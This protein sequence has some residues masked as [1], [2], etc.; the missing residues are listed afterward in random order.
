MATPTPKLLNFGIQNKIK[1]YHFFKFF[2]ELGG[3]KWSTVLRHITTY[4][5]MY[6]CEFKNLIIKPTYW[7]RRY[8]LSAASTLRYRSLH[9][10]NLYPNV[11]RWA[12]LNLSISLVLIIFFF[13]FYMFEK[14]EKKHLK[15]DDM[16]KMNKRE[17]AQRWRIFT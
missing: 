12:V 5:W 16:N 1:I 4:V 6:V 15:E 17:D 11:V 7:E 10:Q 9:N 8:L 13:I 14:Y 2:G 3:K